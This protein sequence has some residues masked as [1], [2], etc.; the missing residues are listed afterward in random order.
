MFRRSSAWLLLLS[1]STA[2]ADG[3]HQ[4]DFCATKVEISIDRV[5]TRIHIRG[6]EKKHPSIAVLVPISCLGGE[7]LEPAT[8]SEAV[9]WL[10]LALPIDYKAGLLKGNTY[11]HSPYGESVDSDLAQFF[12]D[13][14]SLTKDRQICVDAWENARRNNEITDEDIQEA[15]FCGP[16]L[17][18]RL[19]RALLERHCEIPEG[20]LGLAEPRGCVP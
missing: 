11:L 6:E 5:Q 12:Q 1:A 4:T 10:D 20:N 13:R 7:L 19:R 18:L 9:E 16:E 14:W 2:L 8:L 17:I 3:R 15:E